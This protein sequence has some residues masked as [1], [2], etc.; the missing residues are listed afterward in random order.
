MLTINKGVLAIGAFALLL[1]LSGCNSD[2]NNNIPAPPTPTPPDDPDPI[3]LGGF[4]MDGPV[5]GG[6]LYL[7]DSSQIDAA[8]SDAEEAEDRAASLA[9]ADPIATITREDGDEAEFEIEVSG[10][11]AGAALFV[12]FDSAGAEDLT[13]GDEPFNLESVVVLGEA[14]DSHIVNV[15]PHTST[16]AQQVRVVL[17]LTDAASSPDV[18][19]TEILAATTN[20]TTALGVDA[21]GERILP[22][23]TDIIAAEDE[24]LLEEASTLLGM[25]VRSTAIFLDTDRESVLASLGLDALD[26]DIDG[27]VPGDID[28]DEDTIAEIE[29]ID[30]ILSEAEVDVDDF[31]IG[32]CA[33]SAEILGSACA[34]DVR[35]DFLEGKAI[36]Q[37]TSDQEEFDECFADVEEEI[38]EMIEECDDVLEARIELCDDLDDAVHEPE[39]GADFADNFV[40]PLTIGDTTA[41]NPWF[42]L[43][44]G[45]EWV[46]EGTFEDDEGEEVTETITVTVTDRTKLIDGVTCLVV[47]DRAE[48]D[49][50]A[51]EVTDDW[52]AQDVDG[53]IWYCGEVSREFESFDG[54]DPEEPELVELE[55][56]WKSGRDGAKAGIL[57]PME[58]EVGD[59]FRQ[60]VLFGE[61]EDVVEILSLEG[62]QTSPAASCEA[63]CL[64]TLDTTPLEPDVEENKYYVAGIG[65]IAE[66]DLESGERV[67]LQSYTLS[68]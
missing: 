18:V 31:V 68:P 7:F 32:S 66:E 53:N 43:V 9:G 6:T 24:E 34:S 25:S 47:I 36:C 51:I 15:T 37:D 35:D 3:T 20:V 63:T 30:E 59:V 27:A 28:L 48:E 12:V 67:E 49:D 26:G 29:E 4:V 40:D 52:Y 33:S 1:V 22:V 21:F 2:S 61:A 44:V 42:P 55:G 41:V 14:G 5:Q 62:T 19:A 16:I 64:V 45:N 17:D 50:A 46:Y 65:L 58:P 13:F 38:E 11:L 39:F 8:L 10:D 60:E 23:D 57:I 54:D 56:S